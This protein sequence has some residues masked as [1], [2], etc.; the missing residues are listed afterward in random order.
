[1]NPRNYFFPI[2]P[3]VQLIEDLSGA[4]V[5]VDN[6]LGAKSSND[7]ITGIFLFSTTYTDTNP[8]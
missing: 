1:V 7:P 6:Q 4:L 8:S 3:F 2:A 5:Y